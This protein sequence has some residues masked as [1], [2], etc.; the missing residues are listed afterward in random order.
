MNEKLIFI[1]IK[2]TTTAQ[3]TW[4]FHIFESCS[5]V[6]ADVMPTTFC[7]ETNLIFEYF[8]TNWTLT[9][10]RRWIN[11]LNVVILT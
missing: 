1:N 4:G 2:A 7:L 3:R 5:A 9:T 11:K 8:K 6:R 10:I